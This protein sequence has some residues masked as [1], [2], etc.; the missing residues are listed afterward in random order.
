MKTSSAG[1]ILI[2]RSEGF[3]G[4]V[5]RD[6][7]GNLTIGY[8]HKLLHAESFPMGIDPTFAAQ[9]LLHDV[10]DAEAA[11][12]RLVK[13]PLTQGQ[14]DALVD[15]VYNLGEERLATSTLLLDLNGGHYA[16]AA[17]QMLRWDHAGAKELAGL[18]AR[19]QA[20]VV[21]WNSTTASTG[22]ALCPA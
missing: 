22:G 2:K 14:F 21:L 6:A 12:E 7:V 3:R 10:D 11:I 9:I 19:R 15:F 5:Y 18:K 20:E 4:Q 16:Q 17:E 8:G 13:V 1:L